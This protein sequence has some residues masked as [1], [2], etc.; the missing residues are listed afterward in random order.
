MPT[1]AEL[2]TAP[3]LTGL[4]HLA[5]PLDAAPVTGV[6]GDRADRIPAVPPGTVAILL[7]AVP[8][9]LLDVAVRRGGGRRH[10][11]R[12]RRGH[13]TA[14]RPPAH[15]RRVPW[16]SSPARTC[17]PPRPARASDDAARATP[18]SSPTAAGSPS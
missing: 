4:H 5:G 9:H 8:G 6:L 11:A 17:L 16:A 15:A 18:R 2:L 13:P 1:L 10:R 3:G 14:R 12:A 7:S